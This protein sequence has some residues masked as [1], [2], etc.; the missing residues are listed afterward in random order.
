V[1]AGLALLV[2]LTACGSDGPSACFAD[3]RLGISARD[4]NGKPLCGIVV[5]AER[6]RTRY[7]LQIDSWEGCSETEG[8]TVFSLQPLDPGTYLV[9][10]EKP[11]YR[12]V[13][14]TEELRE[15]CVP[16][17]MRTVTLQ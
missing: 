1:K 4:A 13:T 16:M 8:T 7:P 5:T 2:A 11:G 10:V 15:R 3:Q 12:G 17:T 6:E 9:S 14:F